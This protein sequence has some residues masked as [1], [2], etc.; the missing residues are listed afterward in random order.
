MPIAKKNMPPAKKRKV[1]TFSK[2]QVI[3]SSFSE[4]ID[5]ANKLLAAAVLLKKK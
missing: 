4:K 3:S 2:T 5:K 1:N